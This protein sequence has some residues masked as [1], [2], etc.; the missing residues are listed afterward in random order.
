MTATTIDE[1]AARRRAIEALRSGV[2]S[3]D[4]VALLGSGQPEVEDR[5]TELLDQVCQPNRPDGRRSLTARLPRQ[6][7][8]LASTADESTT[9]NR[10][11]ASP[12]DAVSSFRIKHD[13]QCGLAKPGALAAER[14][15]RVVP[16]IQEWLK[17]A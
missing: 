7:H 12:A 14:A 10:S 16:R 15:P 11:L 8:Y 5:F 1:L 2:P 3:W 17:S 6:R 4:A 13:I 9:Q